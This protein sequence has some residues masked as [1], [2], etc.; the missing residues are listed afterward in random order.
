M[1]IN[2]TGFI[3]SMSYDQCVIDLST[4]DKNDIIMIE[5]KFSG[6][7]RS[8]MMCVIKSTKFVL[9]MT[10]SVKHDSARNNG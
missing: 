4:N 6:I 9:Y 5:H 1:T 3:V 7:R 8:C 10:I 2:I